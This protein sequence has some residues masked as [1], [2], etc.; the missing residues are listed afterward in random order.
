MVLQTKIRFFSN[1]NIKNYMEK[2]TALEEGQ[3]FM[4]NKVLI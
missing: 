1:K 4:M 3:M 2:S